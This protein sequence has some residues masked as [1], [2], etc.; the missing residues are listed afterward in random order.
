MGSK[1]RKK[2]TAT[3]HKTTPGTEKELRSL[4]NSCGMN[5]AEF[6]CDR[7]CLCLVAEGEGKEGFIG[8]LHFQRAGETCNG[9]VSEFPLGTW[10]GKHGNEGRVRET[11][12]NTIGREQKEKSRES[13]RKRKRYRR[14][15]MTYCYHT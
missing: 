13:K 1:C 3:Q 2:V 15:G 7:M 14:K 4:L 10:E 11:E 6:T 5:E 12:K 9:N 8:T